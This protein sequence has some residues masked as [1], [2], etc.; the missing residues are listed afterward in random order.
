[1][2]YLLHCIRITVREALRV[3]GGPPG[4]GKMD[5]NPE[6]AKDNPRN[7]P[8]R[9]PFPLLTPE[10]TIP[11][12]TTLSILLRMKSRLGL[13]AMV[14]YMEFYV[15]TIEEHNPTLKG[16]VDHALSLMNVQKIYKDAMGDEDK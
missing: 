16:A 7:Y 9:Q 12:F 5:F 15:H 1:M 14:E 8:Q 13:E 4:E 3:L 10:N 6:Y 2:W 11:I